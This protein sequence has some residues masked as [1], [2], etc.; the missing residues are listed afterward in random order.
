MLQLR[1]KI[2][3]GDILSLADSIEYT[4]SEHLDNIHYLDFYNLRWLVMR[5]RQKATAVNIYDPFRPGVNK[6]VSFKIDINVAN[7]YTKIINLPAICWENEYLSALHYDIL[8]QIDR[9]VKNLNKLV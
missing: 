3:S 4:V 2:K 5:L 7:T 9:Q 1:I 6:P 8:Q